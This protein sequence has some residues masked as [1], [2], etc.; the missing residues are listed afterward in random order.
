MAERRKARNES[1]TPAPMTPRT[2]FTCDMARRPSEWQWRAGTMWLFVA[3]G[4]GVS[5]NIGRTKVFDS[6]DRAMRFLQRMVVIDGRGNSSAWDRCRA[7]RVND[8]YALDSL[9]I[10]H[11]KEMYSQ[12]LR[13]ELVLLRYGECEALNATEAETS[14]TAARAAAGYE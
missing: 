4:S 8:T 1:R 9:Q 2:R 7:A 10:L 3:P 5:V 13:H 11:H 12:E 6:W 14:A